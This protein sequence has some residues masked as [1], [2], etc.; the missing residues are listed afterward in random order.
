MGI[1]VC[2]SVS[3]LYVCSLCKRVPMCTY[4]YSLVCVEILETRLRV[5]QNTSILYGNK[6]ENQSL[7]QSVLTE[8]LIS[9][10][11]LSVFDQLPI[12]LSLNV[13][14]IQS[15]LCSLNPDI[16]PASFLVVS[17]ENISLF[18]RLALRLF[19]HSNFGCQ[20][21]QTHSI[22]NCSNSPP[23]CFNLAK[24]VVK[25]HSQL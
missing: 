25:I 5:Q 21:V 16:H 2:V 8:F 11:C 17:R 4:L 15:P 23:H 3:L 9:R 14:L 10:H 13:F 18:L 12:R 24:T 1:L 19:Q 7:C 20:A 6:G 22:P